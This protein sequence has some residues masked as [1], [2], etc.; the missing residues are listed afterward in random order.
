M[1]PL[2][3]E[4]RIA[5][6]AVL[7]SEDWSPAYAHAPAQ[8]AALVKITAD[9]EVA[10]MRYFRDLAKKVPSL[11]NWWYYKAQSVQAYNVQVMINETEVAAADQEFIKVI[12]DPLAKLQSKGAEAAGI[13]YGSP[14]DLPA[15]GSIIN[16]LT[17]QQVGA[18]IGK[19]TDDSGRLVDNP[20][21]AYSIDDTTR[22][23]INNAIKKSLNLGYSQE[24]AA[25]EVS[26]YIADSARASMIARTEGV[27]AYNIGSNEYAKQAGY[28]GK[29]WTTAGAIDY[30]QDNADEGV[31]PFDQDFTSGAAFAP[32][33]PN[34]RCYTAYT[35]ELP[36]SST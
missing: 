21:T 24:E 12:F 11:V 10:L 31:I 2:E 6:R 20:K 32:A 23:L 19:T 17:T 3:D 1:K 14:I 27:R 5:S 29:Y 16:D 15:T 7:A 8:H 34:C 25:S 26:D 18:L 9:L 4:L 28:K 22:D 36:A 35:P 33:H 30:C 13:Q